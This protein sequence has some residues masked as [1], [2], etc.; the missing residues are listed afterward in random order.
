MEVNMQQQI[1][2]IETEIASLQEMEIVY[3]LK[4]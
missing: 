1:K 2:R 3:A 4:D